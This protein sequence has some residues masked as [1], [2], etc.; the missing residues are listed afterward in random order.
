MN[1]LIQKKLCMGVFTSW[2]NT[3]CVAAIPNPIP[4]KLIPVAGFIFIIMN[5][6]I[7]AIIIHMSHRRAFTPANAGNMNWVT[8][9]PNPIDTRNNP[10]C[11]I[12]V[13]A[14]ERKS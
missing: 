1:Q 7:R 11:T 13:I 8:A 2:G 5:T 10:P 14:N 12:V 6:P 9:I 3:F 4:S